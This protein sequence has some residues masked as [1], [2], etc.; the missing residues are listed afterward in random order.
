M[1]YDRV[2][3]LDDIQREFPGFWSKEV[4]KAICDDI[5]LKAGDSKVV[6]V[7]EEVGAYLCVAGVLDYSMTMD[8]TR[9]SQNIQNRTNHLY[10]GK[11]PD[12]EMHVFNIGPD[13]FY[14]RLA[15]SI[16]MIPVKE[17]EFNLGAE[18]HPDHANDIEFFGIRRAREGTQLTAFKEALKQVIGNGDK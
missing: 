1:R 8:M 13:A 2:S 4:A 12:T 10:L 5:A 3:T 14:Q 18:Y 16:E 6:E 17:Q 11:I 15:Y 9:D 7:T